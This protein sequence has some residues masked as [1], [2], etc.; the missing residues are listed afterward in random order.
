LNGKIQS[1]QQQEKKQNGKIL[2][3]EREKEIKTVK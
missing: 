1:Q 3:G 2:V